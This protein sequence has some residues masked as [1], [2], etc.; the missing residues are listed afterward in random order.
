MV[1]VTWIHALSL[2]S[3][4]WFFGCGMSPSYSSKKPI[5]VSLPHWQPY[6][7]EHLRTPHTCTLPST[8]V[9]W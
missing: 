6:S 9:R 5:T 7:A 3:S 4:L 8:S 2:V 1:P